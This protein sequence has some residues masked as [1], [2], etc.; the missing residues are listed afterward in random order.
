MEPLRHSRYFAA[1][2]AVGVTKSGPTAHPATPGMSASA[3]APCRRT[4]MRR[5]AGLSAVGS[6]SAAATIGHRSAV[7]RVNAD[8]LIMAP[9]P[10][11]SLYHL[12]TLF[13]AG[14]CDQFATFA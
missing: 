3:S 12:L 11:A 14:S 6:K 4:F 10:I 5:A 2:G 13:Q 8:S 9:S 7:R 1:T